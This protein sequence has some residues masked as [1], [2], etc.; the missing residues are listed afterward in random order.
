MCAIAKVCAHY[1]SVSTDNIV[2]LSLGSGQ[3]PNEIPHTVLEA[4]EDWGL[5]TWTP[6]LLSMLTDS[7]ALITD[8]NLKLMLKNRFE[9]VNVTLPR[10]VELDDVA[11]M[12][13]LIGLADQIDL[14][15]TKQ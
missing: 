13:Y 11:E 3:T 1:P 7:G 4:T 10:P 6:Y 15:N 9:R 8:L 2:V 12:P 14:V 5:T